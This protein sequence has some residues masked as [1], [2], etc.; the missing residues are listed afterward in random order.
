MKSWKLH[1]H[2]L[3][4]YWSFYELFNA[5][6]WQYIKISCWSIFETPSKRLKNHLLKALL[7]CN[8]TQYFLCP[9]MIL[10]SVRLSFLWAVS[11]DLKPCVDLCSTSQNF[12]FFN[13]ATIKEM[14]KIKMNVLIDSFNHFIC[15]LIDDCIDGGET[16]GQ[17]WFVGPR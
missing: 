16:T 8:Y 7:H 3:E 10:L 4:L 17:N 6:I 13:Q 1:I 9:K 5:K 15:L 2:F 14:P 12:I 11:M